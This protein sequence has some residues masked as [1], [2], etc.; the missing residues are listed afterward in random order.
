[1][2]GLSVVAQ[3]ARLIGL[4]SIHEQSPGSFGRGI[5]DD[6]QSAAGFAN[7]FAF[8]SE[9]FY[10][11]EDVGIRSLGI[12]ESDGYDISGD[13]R[14]VVGDRTRTV[15]EAFRWSPDGGLQMLG[16]L[17][18]GE[19]W[20]SAIAVSEDGSVV[21][22]FSSSE[23]SRLIEGFYWT[24]RTGMVALGGLYEGHIYSIARG[25]SADGVTVVGVS[26]VADG[27]EAFRWTSRD[28][29]V[30]LGFLPGQAHLSEA[31]GVSPD[32]GVI[33][34][35]AK[36]GDLGEAFVWTKADGMVGLGDLQSQVK[37]SYA[38]AASLGGEVIVGEGTLNGERAVLWTQRR[39]IISLEEL[40]QVEFLL[41]LGDWQLRNAQ[42]VTPDGHTIVGHGWH[43][44]TGTPEGFLAYLPC[45]DDCVCTDTARIKA[46]CDASGVKARLRKSSPRHP[47][48]FCL[49]G[50]RCNT[51]RVDDFGRAKVR[52]GTVEGG[53]HQV[54]IDEC[55]AL[56]TATTCP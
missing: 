8:F 16:D 44:D 23:R 14:F 19:Y 15:T 54:S 31:F 55:E 51:V 6:G 11:Q 34:G 17:P 50:H 28:G 42:A 10:W 25:V 18:G 39:A 48:T 35:R 32:G 52:W 24:A 43:L 36:S 49:D 46:R 9:A 38:F 3:E 5:A 7:S 1:M 37:D 33:V 27:Q 13:G 4:G 56:T 30:G 29:M 41:D 47:A 40:L 20:S 12:G 2:Y 21:V 26:K 22:G 45:I 53:E